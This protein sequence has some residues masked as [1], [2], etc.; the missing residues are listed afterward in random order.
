MRDEIRQ[1]ISNLKPL[2]EI[3][4]EHIRIAL[5]WV[6]STSDLF[7]REAPAIPDPHLVAYFVII[8]PKKDQ[9]LLVDHKRAKL[10]LPPGGHVEP[11]E[12]PMDTVKREAKEELDVEAD[13]VFKDPVFL[14]V[15]HVGTHTDITLWYLLYGDSAAEWNFDKR[16]FQEVRWFTWEDIA[17]V[18]CD[19]NLSR[20]LKRLAALV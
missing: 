9:L 16:E 17:S 1:L 14:T 4:E 12:H 5:E 20:F 13:F 11:D 10:W 7:R 2:D 6:D 8:S 15:A 19:P 18:A 3:E